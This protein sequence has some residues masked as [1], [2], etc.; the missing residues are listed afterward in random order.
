[1][2]PEAAHVQLGLRHVAGRIPSRPRQHDQRDDDR[3]EHDRGQAGDGDL[4]TD[5]G[6]ATSYWYVVIP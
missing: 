5:V 6:E 2:R 4:G 1:M 3:N